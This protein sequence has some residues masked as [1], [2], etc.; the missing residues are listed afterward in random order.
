[1]ASDKIDRILEQWQQ[2]LP[3]VNVAPLAVTG[4]LL[5][6]AR[7]LEKQRE[8]LLAKYG[9]SVWSFDVLATLRRQGP[10]YQLKPTDLYSLLMLSSGAMTN[11]IDRLEQDGIVVRSRS[12]SDRRSVIVQLTPKGIALADAVMPVLFAQEGALL[13]EFATPEEVERLVPLLRRLLL[14]MDAAE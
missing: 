12:G 4:R 11:R 6:I 10:P 1:M 3:Q 8:T 5:R 9:L 13:S 14:A 7:L 2:E